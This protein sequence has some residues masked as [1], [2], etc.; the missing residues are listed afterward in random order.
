M[1]TTIT[2]DEIADAQKIWGE[3]I[4]AFGKAFTDKGDFVKHSPGL[5]SY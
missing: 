4:V 1:G 3:G 2:A 5:K